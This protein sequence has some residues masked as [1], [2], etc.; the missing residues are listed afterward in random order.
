MRVCPK[1]RS[2]TVPRLFR[3]L[4]KA[5]YIHILT[6]SKEDLALDAT[7]IL[8][9]TNQ[10][11]PLLFSNNESI[12]TAAAVIHNL[13]PIFDLKIE[14]HFTS[15]NGDKTCNIDRHRRNDSNIDSMAPPTD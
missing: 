7:C 1:D 4:R 14:G 11:L 5:A 2:E 12:L 3:P 15:K 6:T 9:R 8:Y 10:V 13:P